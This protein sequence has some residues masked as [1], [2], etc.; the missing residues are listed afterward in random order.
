MRQRTKVSNLRMEIPDILCQQQ[1]EKLCKKL[2][3]VE[4]TNP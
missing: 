1:Q 3:W 2:F 4:E